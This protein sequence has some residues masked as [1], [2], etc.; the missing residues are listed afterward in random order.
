MEKWDLLKLFQEW[1]K[2]ENKGEWWRGWI[3]LWYIWYKSIYKCHSVL[4]AQQFFFKWTVQSAYITRR[5]WQEFMYQ[6][7]NLHANKGLSS[8]ISKSSPGPPEE[9]LP[10]WPRWKWLEGH[11]DFTRLVLLRVLV[12]KASI[13]CLEWLWLEHILSCGCGG[14]L[15]LECPQSIY[16][17]QNSQCAL[18]TIWSVASK[19][20]TW[21]TVLNSVLPSIREGPVKQPAHDSFNHSQKAF[22]G[23]LQ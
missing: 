14:F 2:R 9:M 15:L 21:L 7:Q 4:P 22:K 11:L 13:G 18:G 16:K 12:S 1:G 10:L 23:C 8:P 17:C 3:Q 19:G 6:S 20:T 5:T